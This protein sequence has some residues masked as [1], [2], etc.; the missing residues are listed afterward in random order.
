CALQRRDLLGRR[1]DVDFLQVVDATVREELGMRLVVS[2]DFSRRRLRRTLADLV[3]VGTGDDLASRRLELLLD[4][5]LPVELL[6]FG[7]LELELLVDQPLE[8]LSARR[9]RHRG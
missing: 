7:L 8:R 1:L 5:R 2:G 6:V 3:D 4:S 9:G